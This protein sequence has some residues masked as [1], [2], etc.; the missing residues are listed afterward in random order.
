MKKLNICFF[1]VSLSFLNTQASFQGRFQSIVLSYKN[2]IRSFF[3]ESL[4]SNDGN[5]YKYYPNFEED[6]D[7]ID[8]WFNIFDR[9]ITESCILKSLELI[10]NKQ[11]LDEQKFSELVAT[12]EEFSACIQISFGISANESPHLIEYPVLSLFFSHNNITKKI[13]SKPGQRK[14]YIL[15]NCFEAFID[16]LVYGKKLIDMPP[17]RKFWPQMNEFVISDIREY[18]IR[19]SGG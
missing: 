6:S 17:G 18:N 7:Y 19:R 15:V 12:L 4:N 3:I 14:I 1:I 5:H 13:I 16:D 8:R 2:L 10:D 9:F 11:P